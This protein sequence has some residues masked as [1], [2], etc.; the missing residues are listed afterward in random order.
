MFD[1]AEHERLLAQDASSIDAFRERQQAAYATEVA[2][3]QNDPRVDAVEDAEEV[4]MQAVHGSAVV[5]DMWGNV[6]K[7]LV[8]VGQQVQ[9]GEPLVILEAM[10]MEFQVAARQAGTVAALHCKAGEP[11]AAGDALVVI[12][13]HPVAATAPHA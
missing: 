3:W 10:K 13:P 2:L 1:L 7:V 9:I 4:V 6:W 5:A 12:R 8:D 11:V